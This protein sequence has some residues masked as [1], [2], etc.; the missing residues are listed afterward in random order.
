MLSLER[1]LIVLDIEALQ[2]TAARRMASLGH[3]TAAVELGL[4]MHAS[5]ITTP[6][7]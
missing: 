3:S 2:I 1:P 4:G 5:R 6:Y 7:E